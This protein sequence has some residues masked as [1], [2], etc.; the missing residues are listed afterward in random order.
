MASKQ[1]EV[2]TFS[3]E[4]EGLSAFSASVNMTDVQLVAIY[5]LL[6][7]FHGHPSITQTWTKT[8]GVH[9]YVK[10]S[11]HGKERYW[12]IS[13]GGNAIELDDWLS[14]DVLTTQGGTDG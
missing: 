14:D 11:R 1:P 10:I 7:A 13:K 9:T 12:H 8:G 6:S 4:T 5:T 3:T 2:S